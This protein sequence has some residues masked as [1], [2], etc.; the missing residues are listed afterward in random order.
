MGR[1]Y[2]AV[3]SHLPETCTGVFVE[4]GSDRGEG[5]TGFLYNMAVQKHTKLISVDIDSRA[6]LRNDPA[7][8]EYVTADAGTWTREFDQSIS[9][10]YLDNFDYIWDISS[11]TPA[12]QAQMAQYAARGQTMTNQNCQIVH[13]Q[14]LLNLYD[15]LLPDCVVVMDDTYCVNDCWIGK[16]G[17]GVVFLRAQGWN[18]VDQSLDCGVILSR[19]LTNDR[20]VL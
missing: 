11:V 9:L 4:I 14:Q 1:I 16:C 20:P 12:Q 15:K 17:P 5:S 7:G 13:M 18:I 10:L 6:R 8:P 3:E 2:Q 19:F